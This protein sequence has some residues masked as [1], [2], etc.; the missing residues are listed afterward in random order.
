M[1]NLGLAPT[2]RADDDR[3]AVCT[4]G[5]AR[6]LWLFSYMRQVTVDRQQRRVTVTTTRLWFW[7]DVR[8][9]AFD[10][11]SRIVYRGQGVPS[12]QFWRY[13]SADAGGYESAFFLIS[14]FLKDRQHELVLFT[15]WE[16]QPHPNDWLE[17]IS[18]GASD[19]ARL[20]DEDAVRLVELLH[21][22]IGVPIARH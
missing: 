4:C 7:R 16:E 17:S 8:V 11:I 12:L 15:V 1:D 18:G 10:Q 14:L 3:L 9:I 5:L 13:L 2:V 19:Q 21:R 20:G 22:Y 6:L